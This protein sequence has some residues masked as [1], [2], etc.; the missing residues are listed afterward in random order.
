MITVRK[1]VLLLKQM[2]YKEIMQCLYCGHKE[3]ANTND[4][5]LFG[6]KHFRSCPGCLK[7][8]W[9]GTPFGGYE[10]TKWARCGAK[11]GLNPACTKSE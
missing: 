2:L 11:E 10:E 6:K 1:L 9:E 3:M 4:P 7:R 8:M 5:F